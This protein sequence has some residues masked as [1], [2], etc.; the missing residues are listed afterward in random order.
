MDEPG[1]LLLDCLHDLGMTMTCRIDGYT[2]CE[3][4]KRVPVD[5]FNPTSQAAFDYKRV[6]TRI[7]WRDQ[8]FIVVNEPAGTWTRK[9]AR[10]MRHYGNGRERCFRA[11]VRRGNHRSPPQAQHSNHVFRG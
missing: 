6:A 11:E 9:K 2:G 7:A 1:A 3:V 4:Q 10:D 5:I 8:R